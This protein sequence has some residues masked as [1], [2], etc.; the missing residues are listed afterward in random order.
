MLVWRS[1]VMNRG[2]S[3]TGRLVRCDAVARPSTRPKRRKKE[4]LF[5]T[6][7]R[8]VLLLGS[9]SGLVFVLWKGVDA[10]PMI[11][12]YLL[13]ERLWHSGHARCDKDRP[14]LGMCH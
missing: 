6:R 13:R 11:T 4:G 12:A 10:C 14:A 3:K 7:K 1:E 2:S 5:R 8:L 9:Q